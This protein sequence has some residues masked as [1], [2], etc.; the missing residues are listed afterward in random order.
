[1]SWKRIDYIILLCLGALQR[2]V[3]LLPDIDITRDTCLSVETRLMRAE[4][5]VFFSVAH[6]RST[7]QPFFSYLLRWQI[8]GFMFHFSITNFFSFLFLRLP[9]GSRFPYFE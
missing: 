5:I 8:D 4:S 1:M 9:F 7:C 2:K 3:D 6:S